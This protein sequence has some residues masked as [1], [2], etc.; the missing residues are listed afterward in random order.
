MGTKTGGI[1]CAGMCKIFG[2]EASDAH[3]EPV[4]LMWKAGRT[5]TGA[6]TEAVLTDASADI[7]I[8]Q[9]VRVGERPLKLCRQ[10]KG[11]NSLLPIPRVARLP[12]CQ[13]GRAVGV[14]K[15]DKTK[16]RRE[17][18]EVACCGVQAH[19]PPS[20]ARELAHLSMYPS[21]A[22][23]LP[24][25][26]AFWPSMESSARLIGMLYEGVGGFDRQAASGE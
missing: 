4:P 15:R 21:E 7:R 3:A 13:N 26:P 18:G 24:I 17:W 8:A 6:E 11:T 19:S 2:W 16:P 22:R 25:S 1:V 9:H 12:C 20:V 14:C 23:A 5:E 10:R